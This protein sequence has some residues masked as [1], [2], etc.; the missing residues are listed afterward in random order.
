[1]P[2]RLKY[3]NRVSFTTSFE[4]DFLREVSQR[5][6]EKD[7]D[8]NELITKLLEKWMKEDNDDNNNKNAQLKLSIFSNEIIIGNHNHQQHQQNNQ[9]QDKHNSNNHI[10]N[11]KDLLARLPTLEEWNDA[12]KNAKS[13]QEIGKVQRYE[14]T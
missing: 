6:R 14:L 4:G 9:D 5:C 8:R 13:S 10:T 3:K 12:L 11:V 1:M 7:L 2:A